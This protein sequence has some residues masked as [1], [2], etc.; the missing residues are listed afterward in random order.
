MDPCAFPG[1]TGAAVCLVLELWHGDLL[2]DACRTLLLPCS[3]PR[4]H[5]VHDE[6]QALL[7]EGG[8]EGMHDFLADLGMWLS[9]RALPHSSTSAGQ[10]TH[11]T[12]GTSTATTPDDA[13]MPSSAAAPLLPAPMVAAAAHQLGAGLLRQ[14]VLWGTPALAQDIADRL[15]A[16]P[17]AP[18]AFSSLLCPSAEAHA[19][20]GEMRGGGE[21]DKVHSTAQQQGRGVGQGGGVCPKETRMQQGGDGFGSSREAAEHG[22]SSREAATELGGS[23]DI[24]DLGG[25]LHLALLSPCPVRMLQVVLGLDARGGVLLK[26]A[27]PAGADAASTRT[28]A[29]AAGAPPAGAGVDA[30]GGGG[31]WRWGVPNALGIT[32]CT[33]LA[34]LEERQALLQVLREADP[35]AWLSVQEAVGTGTAGQTQAP[36]ASAAHVAA[37]CSAWGL[38]TAALRGALLGFGDGGAAGGRCMPSEQQFAS[39]AEGYTHM[40]LAVRFN[41]LLLGCLVGVAR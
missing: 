26:A 15:M 38:W 21:L 2:L 9:R 20:M 6:L 35:E 31:A 23:T 36:S 8:A 17:A 4:A 19:P 12:A 25:L 29:A 41:V 40:L 27:N 37:A 30:G 28:T 1:G 18:G 10:P 14:A 7:A 11:S 5:E 34:S 32:P 39:W 22:S 24:A 33:I 13:A 3:A 16:P